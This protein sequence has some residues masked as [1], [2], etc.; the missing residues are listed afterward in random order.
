MSTAW[1]TGATGAWGGAF[2]RALLEAGY[3]VLA[4]GRHD[5]PE[6]ALRALELGR[7]WGFVAFDLGHAPS[8]ADLVAGA[9]EPFRGAPD[10]LIHAAVS[11]EGDRVALAG[12]DYLAPAA[13]VEVVVQAMLERGSGRVGVLV[14]QNARLGLAGLGDYSAAQG[15]LW[16]WCEARREE[17]RSAGSLVSLTVV[18][19]PRTASPTQRFVSERSGHSARLAPPDANR[20]LRAV[21]TGRRRAGRRPLLAAIAMAT[22]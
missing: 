22:R 13:L 17:L 10:V 21:L 18:I 1:L 6:L 8:F 20:L 12:S 11:T 3:D 4:L 15:A 5:A 16:T 9:P 2:A 19:P 7:G 14:A